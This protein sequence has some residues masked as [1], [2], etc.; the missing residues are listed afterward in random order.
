MGTLVDAQ[1]TGSSDADVTSGNYCRYDGHALVRPAGDRPPTALT[2]YVHDSF[3]ALVLNE[4]FSCVGARAVV[5]QNAYGFALYD[6]MGVP[7]TTS[8]LAAD[9]DGFL[10]DEVLQQKP[11]SSFVASFANPAPRDE[12]DFESMLWT[13]LQLLNNDDDAPWASRPSADP[14]DPDFSFS[15]RGTGFFIVGLH[16][17][18]SRVARRFAWPTV[19]FN[20]HDQFDRLRDNGTYSRF[21]RVIRAGD[22]ALQGSV[23]PMLSDFGERSEARQYSGRAVTDEW[24]CPFHAHQAAREVEKR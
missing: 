7:E 9:L 4:Q 14:A 5:R 8:A 12:A 13:T 16:G 19:V 21:Q 22:V 10:H 6:R 15:F 18:S 1:L 11:L 20:P 17:S 2:K 23:N 3:R 24:R